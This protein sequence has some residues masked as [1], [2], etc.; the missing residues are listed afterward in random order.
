MAITKN[1]QSKETISGMAKR[2][3]PD[4]QI[5]EI[6]ELTEGMCNVTYDITF[7]DGS[8]SILK[9]ASKDRTNN[10]FFPDTR[11]QDIWA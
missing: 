11:L 7:E 2:A 4:K 6:K 9:I 10:T 8:E 1:R 3:F 5:A